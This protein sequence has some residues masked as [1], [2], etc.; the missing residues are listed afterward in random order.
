[1]KC[2]PRDIKK[3]Y[4]QAGDQGSRAMRKELPD[5]TLDH[6]RVLHGGVLRDGAVGLGSGQICEPV[7]TRV[8]VTGYAVLPGAIDLGGQIGLDQ[9]DGPALDCLATG[10]ATAG[11]TTLFVQQEAGAAGITTG[12]ADTIGASS[13]PD[14]LVRLVVGSHQAE[15]IANAVVQL[16]A[17][18]PSALTFSHPS[19][20]DRRRIEAMEGGFGAV[21]RRLAD[22]AAALDARGVNYGSDG[23]VSAETREWMSM[24]GARMVSRP[25]TRQAAATARAMG[26]PVILSATD[27]LTSGTVRHGIAA[28]L[29]GEG[30][31]DALGSFGRPDAALRVVTALVSSGRMSLGHAWALISSAPAGI[32]GLSDRGGLVMGTRADIVLMETGSMKVA[33]TICAGRL[34]YAD[35]EI[36]ARFEAALSPDALAA[37]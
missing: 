2:H 13:W 25:M 1:M 5:L 17:H 15:N 10:A 21:A 28:A 22:L 26:E 32:M 30:M 6:G 31:C 7:A 36:R 37:E 34:I 18:C 14:I 35:A 16:D 11:T 29:L 20:A 27:I 4:P 3:S 24:I 33:A 23:D 9:A 12:T 8:D 19:D